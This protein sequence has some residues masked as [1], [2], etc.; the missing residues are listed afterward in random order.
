[1]SEYSGFGTCGIKDFVSE[2]IVICPGK[3]FLRFEY[4]MI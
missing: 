3:L 1:M 2:F 4:E